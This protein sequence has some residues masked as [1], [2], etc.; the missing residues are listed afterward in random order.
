M[1]S[2]GFYPLLRNIFRNFPT[3]GLFRCLKPLDRSLQCL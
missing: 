2:V 1:R 3:D